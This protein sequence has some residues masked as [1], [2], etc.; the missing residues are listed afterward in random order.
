MCNDDLTDPMYS[1][2]GTT[3]P[4]GKCDAQLVLQ[5]PEQMKNDII[6]V[7]FSDNCPTPSE[8][9][10]SLISRE[11]YGKINMIRLNTKSA[12]V[13][14]LGIHSTNSGK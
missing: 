8:W 4:L 10:R 13:E 1:R 7:A 2:N 9:V 12:S 14:T 3:H 5:L 11:L 6:G